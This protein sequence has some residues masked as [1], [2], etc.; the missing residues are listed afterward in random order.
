MD[1][2]SQEQRKMKQVNFPY[3]GTG[4]ILLFSFFNFYG[5]VYMR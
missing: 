5:A 1:K 3:S 2:N 4:V